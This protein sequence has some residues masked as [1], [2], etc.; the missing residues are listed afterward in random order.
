MPGIGAALT[1]IGP[2]FGAAL[3]RAK[4]LSCVNWS[5]KF[6]REK[7]LS[8]TATPAVENGERGLSVPDRRHFSDETNQ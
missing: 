4:V 5:N 2:I 7:W 3:A 6:A 8:R 1:P